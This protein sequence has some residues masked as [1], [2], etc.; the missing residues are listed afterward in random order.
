MNRRRFLKSSL[1]WVPAAPAIVRAAVIPSHRHASAPK[2]A[3]AGPSGNPFITTPGIGSLRNNFE[4]WVGLYFAMEGAHTI[5]ALGRYVH[6]GNSQT[7][8]LK[9]TDNSCNTLGSVTVDCNGATAGQFLYAAL[10]SPISVTNHTL[11]YLMS[12]E[13]IGGDQWSDNTSQTFSA[14]KYSADGSFGVDDTSCAGGGTVDKC[15]VPVNFL[16]TT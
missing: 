7:H 12:R 16:Y 15:F 9:L 13:T 2:P 8:T 1:L 6:S 14:D 11:Y 3:A 10:S 4:K 5:T